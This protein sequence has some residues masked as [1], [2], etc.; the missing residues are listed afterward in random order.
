MNDIRIL[1][2]G[3]GAIVAPSILR[4]YKE[5]KERNIYIVGVDIK[6]KVKNKYI[7]AYYQYKKPTDEKYIETLIN[8]CTKEKIDFIIPLVDSELELLSE[9]KETF[10]KNNIT[11]CVND[12]E[13]IRLIQKKDKL[14]EFLKDNNIDVPEYVLFN[15]VDEFIRG[16]NKLNYPKETIC[17]KPVNSSGSRGFR[18]IKNEIDY[19]KYLFEEKP[20]SKYINYEFLIDAMRKCKN[21]PNMML[22]EY[23]SG[24]LFNVNVL[25]DNGKIIY[26]VAGKVINFGLGNTIE[27]EIVEKKDIVNYCSKI[28][29]LLNLSGNIGFEVAYSKDNKLK[30]IEI[31]IRVQGQIYSST[32]AGINFP[33]YELKYYLKEDLPNIPNVNLIR[34]TRYFEDQCL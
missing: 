23:V 32:L 22:M 14:Y 30:L 33:Y 8:I 12:K 21:I 24:D 25:A 11:V 28:T 4:S 2:T 1:V 15:N 26:I 5:V 17:Y 19:E 20:D 31:N 6:D 29:E 3:V 16:C 9:N 34:M 13:K 10:D 18:I 7:D 27:C